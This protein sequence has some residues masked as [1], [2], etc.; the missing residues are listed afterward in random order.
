MKLVEN[1]N[2][3]YAYIEYPDELKSIN[4]IVNILNK[5]LVDS[6]FDRYQYKT[7]KRGKKV[8]IERV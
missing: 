4:D 2:E 3:A 7:I 6:G 8:F 1:E 5:D